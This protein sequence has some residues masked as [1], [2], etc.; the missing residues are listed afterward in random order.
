MKEATEF[1]VS[2]V[3]IW[4]WVTG[5]Q[6]HSGPLSGQP[7]RHQVVMRLVPKIE[8]RGRGSGCFTL[9]IRPLGEIGDANF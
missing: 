9:I 5:P 7:L 8:A 4:S 3:W 6:K 2:S 1:T